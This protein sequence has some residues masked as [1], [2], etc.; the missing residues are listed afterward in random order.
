MTTVAVL[1]LDAAKIVAGLEERFPGVEYLAGATFDDLGRRTSEVDVLVTRGGGEGWMISAADIASLP[2]LAW[3]QGMVSGTDHF[4]EALSDRPEILLTSGRGIHGPPVSEMAVFHM[5][6]LS[7]QAR[8][9]LR[10]QE[11]RVWDRTVELDLLQGKTVGILGMGVIGQYLARLCKAFGMTVVGCARTPRQLPD[12]DEF[13]PADRLLE[14]AACADF[15]VLLIPLTEETRALIDRQFLATM[16]PTAYVLNFARGAVIDEEALIEA[17]DAGTIGGAGL[18]ALLQEPLPPESP[19]WGY[20][21]VLVTSHLAGESVRY[22]DQVL[23]IIERNLDAYLRG[24]LDQMIN[25]VA[26]S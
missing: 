13:I 2:Q 22:A 16:K 4:Q 21:N 17:L 6:A 1:A 26:R 24:K 5:L 3:V 12:F 14:F 25:V 7:R 19:L 10:L 20:D 8:I 9:L 18:D 23:P 15:I 11:E